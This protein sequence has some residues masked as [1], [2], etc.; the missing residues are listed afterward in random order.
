MIRKFI[1]NPSLFSWSSVKLCAPPPSVTAAHVALSA[2]SQSWC[3]SVPRPTLLV[4]NGRSRHLRSTPP[5][6]R[7][8]RGHLFHESPLRL[9]WTLPCAADSEV[10]ESSHRRSRHS[11]GSSNVTSAW[12]EHR[13]LRLKMTAK[14]RKGKGNHKPEENSLKNEVIESE[15]RAGGNNPRLP[16]VLFLMLVIGGAIGAWFCFQQHQT[17]TYLSDNLTDVQMKMG[18]LQTSHEELRQSSG[19]VRN[20][21]V[22]GWWRAA[23]LFS[24]IDPE[25]LIFALLHTQK[26]TRPRHMSPVLAAS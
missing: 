23:L 22:S 19:K 17:L 11:S 6:S 12:R 9:L 13:V 5:L 16:L 21:K 10:C 7:P 3:R 2:R 15:V 25:P 18:T 1:R 20:Q 4:L 14:H 8:A 24:S 26:K